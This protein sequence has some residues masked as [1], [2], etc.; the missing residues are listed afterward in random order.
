MILNKQVR[1]EREEAMMLLGWLVCAKRPLK[2]H[3]V[4]TMKSVNF[5]GRKV[6]FEQRRFRVG[7]KDLCESLVD[8]RQDGSIEL[9][10]STAKA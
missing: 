6:E 4:Q 8:V 10:H 9:V 2:F 7:P 5:E 1:A 3:E